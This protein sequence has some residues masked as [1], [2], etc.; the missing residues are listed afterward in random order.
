[1][2]KQNNIS[3]AVV[4]ANA[5]G[6]DVGSRQHYVAVGQDPQDVRTFDVYTKDY[7]AIIEW[8]HQKEIVT[9]ALESTGTYRQTLFCGLQTAD[10]EVVLSNNYIKNPQRKTDTKDA[11][12]LQ[13]MRTLGLLKHPFIPCADIA[14]LRTYQRHRSNI[15]AAATA[16][17]QHMQKALRLMNIRLDVTLSDITGF[18]AMKIMEAIISCQKNG[19]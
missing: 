3:M 14:Q 12:W 19:K 15:I 11:R 5:A 10:F 8:L 16:H 1:M 2:K 7:A 6:I 4:N 9:V 18:S 13:K 17:T